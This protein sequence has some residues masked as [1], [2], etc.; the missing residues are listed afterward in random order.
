[1]CPDVAHRDGRQFDGQ[2]LLLGHCGRGWTC[3][4]PRP[5]AMTQLQGGTGAWPRLSAIIMSSRLPASHPDCRAVLIQI[6]APQSI[7]IHDGAR[8]KI[9]RR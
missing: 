8:E 3:G 5:V 1:M 6:V 2:P 7:V 4:L 9:A